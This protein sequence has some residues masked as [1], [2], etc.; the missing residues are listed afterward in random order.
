MNDLAVFVSY[1][2]SDSG[3]YKGFLPDG[4]QIFYI[5]NITEIEK[6]IDRLPEHITKIAWINQ[7]VV[8]SNKNWYLEASDLLDKCNTC[9][10]F[11][12][13]YL[14]D[15]NG[16]IS[17]SNHSSAFRFVN[18]KGGNLHDYEYG[19]AWAFRRTVL[20]NGVVDIAYMSQ[21]FLDTPY[22]I[23]PDEHSRQWILKNKKQKGKS[24]CV[25]GTIILS[26]NEYIKPEHKI[27]DIKKTQVYK[28]VE[29]DVSIPYCK[30]NIKWVSTSVESIL[31]QSNAKVVVHLIADGFKTP[32]NLKELPVNF[33]ETTE[34]IGPYR[35]TNKLFRFLET[36]YIA[37]QDS[38]DIA[39]PHR[40]NY[41]INKM[42]NDGSEMFGA[43][44]RQ[45]CSYETQDE[46]SL[47]YIK[48]QPI[49]ASSEV[50]SWSISP[51]GIVI[52]GTRVM[53]RKLFEKTNGFAPLFMSADCEFTTRCYKYNIPITIDSEIVA[54]R[55]VHG[56]SLSRG[57]R[58]G[59]KSDIRNKIHDSI[60]ETYKNMPKAS[61]ES[62]GSIKQES[63]DG[64]IKV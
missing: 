62:F 6:Y 54:L 49:H 63:Q 39:L 11:E 35:V 5:K 4:I 42:S 9:Q 1:S 17:F 45:F 51:H 41:S 64:I 25:R 32:D 10:L 60:Y 27:N 46:E 52:N 7:N 15:S 34:N 8:F 3:G 2:D 38:D 55:R 58:Y 44:M 61:I 47:Q 23:T 12:S 48:N 31:N 16:R 33:Y 19:V 28:D 43:A 30:N 57:D 18:Q 21:V 22:N 40:I 24:G 59:L 37:I 36:D 20:Q 50:D 56:M 14:T 53:T 29:C 26:D 13:I